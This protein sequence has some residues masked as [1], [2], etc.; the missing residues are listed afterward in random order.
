M[1]F[2]KRSA[3][4][5]LAM[6]PVRKGTGL[7][8]KPD[9]DSYKLREVVL[10][11]DL[12]VN[13]ELVAEA[14]TYLFYAPS[15]TDSSVEWYEAYLLSKLLPDVCSYEKPSSKKADEAKLAALAAENEVLKAQLA[16][17]KTA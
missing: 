8:S 7:P 13:G 10:H 9:H 5:T 6:V 2:Q 17:L 16:A 14:G 12:V 1:A 11:Q 3:A 4:N 15:W